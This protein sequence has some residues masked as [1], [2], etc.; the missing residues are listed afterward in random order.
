MGPK[1]PT[2]QFQKTEQIAHPFPPSGLDSNETTPR[3]T[4]SGYRANKM[5][6]TTIK[7][8]NAMA[9]VKAKPR[10]AYPNYQ[11]HGRAKRVRLACVKGAASKNPLAESLRGGTFIEV[12]GEQ[13]Q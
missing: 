1:K 7:A 10:I 3:N 13:R 6:N 12:H 11:K 5:R 9:S 4:E 8:N 2:C